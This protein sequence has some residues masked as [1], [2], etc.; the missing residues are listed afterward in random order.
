[1]VFLTTATFRTNQATEAPPDW[2]IWCRRINLAYNPVYDITIGS[3]DLQSIWSAAISVDVYVFAPRAGTLYAR[4]INEGSNFT[5]SLAHF[6]IV[7]GTAAYAT[8][9]RQFD[10]TVW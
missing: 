8:G 3:T 9:L 6:G 4:G 5:F 7:G 10:G 1:M 2:L